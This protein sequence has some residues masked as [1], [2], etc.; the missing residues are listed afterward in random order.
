MRRRL[1]FLLLALGAAQTS[2]GFTSCAEPEQFCQIL[3]PDM[4]AFVGRPV[5]MMTERDRYR[6]TF[7][8][9]ENLWGLA[10][11]GTVSVR[12][13]ERLGSFG[14]GFVAA[15]LAEGEFRIDYCGAGV[16][17]PIDD[18]RVQQFRK[19]VKEGK[20][21]NLAVDV[22]SP[23][24]RPIAEAEVELTRGTQVIRGRTRGT[25]AFYVGSISPGEYRVR[26]T[27]THFR[28]LGEFRTSILPGSCAPLRVR[29]EPES[30]VSARVVDWRGEPLRAARFH[31]QG[32]EEPSTG[33]SVFETVMESV[34][35]RVMRL[36]G[37]ESTSPPR[38]ISRSARTDSAGRVIFQGV[39]PGRHYLVSD[40]S[41]VYQP[42]G[43]PLPKTYYP[44][45]YDW[46]NAVRIE[47]GEGRSVEDIWFRLPDFGTKRRVD[48]RVVN[49]DGR[50]VAGAVVRDGR[51]DDDNERAANSGAQQIADR[52]G[53]VTFEVWPVS[54]YRFAVTV[55]GAKPIE[56][57][58]IDVP[59][60]RPAFAGV[61]VVKPWQPEYSPVPIKGDRTAGGR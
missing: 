35:S 52:D 53:R 46:Q 40:I 13:S 48:L 6:T 43:L 18:P 59:A 3:R 49:A 12:S 21:A 58:N 20:V 55:Y 8:V 38:L 34:R 54:D 14:T 32:W 25:R 30:R 31:L 19:D 27:K 17:L 56:F 2:V 7:E 1:G 57:G 24:Y 4:V 15:R 22:H 37:R 39:M 10:T 28:Q 33:D 9:I 47:V 26:V 5:S 61:V 42:W 36:V 23:D 44:G 45:V 16:I 51:L 11:Q 29:L 41:D 60:G 50:P